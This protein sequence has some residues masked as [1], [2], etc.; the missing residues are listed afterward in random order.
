M[1]TD[2]GKSIIWVCIS[3]NWRQLE[4]REIGASEFHCIRILHWSRFHKRTLVPLHSFVRK[5]IQQVFTEPL[6]VV[7]ESLS[8]HLSPCNSATPLI[9]RWGLCLLPWNLGYILMFSDQQNAQK[10]CWAASK[11]LPQEP[12][13]S[14]FI[15]L[16]PWHGQV[17]KKK[18]G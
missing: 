14:D 4:S 2:L 10:W 13:P 17:K 5:F 18:K 3:Q 9:T 15:L 12:L 8:F 1:P 11:F 7:A 6:T 16:E